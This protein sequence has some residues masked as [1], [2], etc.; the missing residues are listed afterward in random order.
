MKKLKIHAKTFTVFV[1]E[2]DV[3][4]SSGLNQ[5]TFKKYNIIGFGQ[6]L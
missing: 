4:K 6:D 1:F 5:N 3:D 2:F